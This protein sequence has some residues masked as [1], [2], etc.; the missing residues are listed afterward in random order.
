MAFDFS[1]S[2]SEDGPK[3]DPYVRYAPDHE[4]SFGRY[5][6]WGV[7]VVVVVIVLGTLGGRGCSA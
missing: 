3:G 1:S 2:A 6:L 4:R 5:H 7:V